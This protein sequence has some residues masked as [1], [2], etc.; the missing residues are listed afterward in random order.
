MISCFLY[1]KWPLLFTDLGFRVKD[2]DAVFLNIFIINFFGG[3]FFFCVI[4]SNF[5]LQFQ[6]WK[7]FY[8]LDP[9]V[10]GKACLLKRCEISRSRCKNHHLP[11]PHSLCIQLCSPFRMDGYIEPMGRA[12]HSQNAQN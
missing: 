10:E 6:P 11:S 5:W 7:F 8:I 3:C 12:N 9:A 1:V 2:E 4:Y